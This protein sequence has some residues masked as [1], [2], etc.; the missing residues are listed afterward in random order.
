MIDSLT[1][2][3]GTTTQK[4][5]DISNLSDYSLLK[6]LAIEALVYD[7]INYPVDSI[8]DY[9]NLKSLYPDYKNPEGDYLAL[10]IYQKK[11]RL[12]IR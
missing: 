4:Y 8:I 7:L 1:S 9:D 12:Q 5:I 3:T 10:D 11:E 2:L 6:G